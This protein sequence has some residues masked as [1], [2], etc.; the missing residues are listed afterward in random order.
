[1]INKDHADGKSNWE[2]KLYYYSDYTEEEREPLEKADKLRG[3]IR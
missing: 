2:A 1:M 3:I